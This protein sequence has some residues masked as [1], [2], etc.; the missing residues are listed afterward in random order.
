MTTVVADA[1]VF[2]RFILG[3]VHSQKM[4]AERLFLKAK[5]GDITLI[6]PQII[7]FEVEFALTKY[8]RFKKSDVIFRLESLLSADYFD[9]DK[10]KFF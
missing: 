4:E 10:K 5:K 1:N 6:V 2:L 7:I 8:Y 3:D 9:V